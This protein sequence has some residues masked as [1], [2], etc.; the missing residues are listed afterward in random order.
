MLKKKRMLAL[1][2]LLV[3]F[4]DA[5]YLVANF[6]KIPHGGYWSLII[7]SIPFVMIVLYTQGQK[8]LYKMMEFMPLEEFLHKFRRSKVLLCF[9]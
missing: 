7:S 9:F 8:R 1:A 6:Y 2:A 3:T 5:A 4:V